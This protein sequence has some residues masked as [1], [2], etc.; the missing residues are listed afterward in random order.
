MMSTILFVLLEM[1]TST[2]HYKS[3]DQGH[4]WHT[5]TVALWSSSLTHSKT[6]DECWNWLSS[7]QMT[8]GEAFSLWAAAWLIQVLTSAVSPKQVLKHFFLIK[9]RKVQG[10]T[11]SEANDYQG[12]TVSKCRHFYSPYR[13][14]HQVKTLKFHIFSLT[15]DQF[16]LTNYLIHQ[17]RKLGIL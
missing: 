5:N 11:S 15:T 1:L 2:H 9:M 4:Q 12:I 3:S 16:S 17:H 13:S 14:L 6:C 7:K 10:L 8:S